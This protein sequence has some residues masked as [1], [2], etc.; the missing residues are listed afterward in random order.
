MQLAM[1]EPILKRGS[2]KAARF[3][4]MVAGQAGLGKTSF[5]ATVFDQ[6]D[7]PHEE[8]GGEATDPIRQRIFTPTT[9]IT[10]YSVGEAPIC[11]GLQG[12]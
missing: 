3:G 12:C 8:V 9:E 4:L 7:P 11:N 1:E 2:R 5:L 6:I 10:A